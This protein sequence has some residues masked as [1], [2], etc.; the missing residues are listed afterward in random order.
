MMLLGPPHPKK[1]ANGG[2]RDWRSLWTSDAFVSL[3]LSGELSVVPTQEM[4]WPW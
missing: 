1:N 3:C 4:K 2:H